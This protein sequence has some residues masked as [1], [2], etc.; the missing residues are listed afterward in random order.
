[1]PWERPDVFLYLSLFLLGAGILGLVSRRSLIGMLVA[2]ELCLNGAGLNFV[3]LQKFYQP[4]LPHGEVFALF[5]MGVA[6]SEAA[7]ALGIVLLFF[8]RR[9][10]AEERALRELKG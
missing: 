2:V 4:S 1:M 5:T 10:T 3:L 8:R 6:A 7:I 9:A